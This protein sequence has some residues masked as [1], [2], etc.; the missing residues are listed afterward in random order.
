M[1]DFLYIMRTFL[2][3]RWPGNVRELRNGMEVAA[4]VVRCDTIGPD[5][6]S[7]EIL[8]GGIP[9]LAAGPIP[10]PAPRTLEEIERDAIRAALR[11]TGGNKTQAARVLGIG[12]R[13]LHRKVKDRTGR[14]ADRPTRVQHDP[15]RRPD[16][17]PCEHVRMERGGTP[18]GPLPPRSEGDRS[19]SLPC[20]SR[21][22]PGTCR[23]GMVGCGN[24]FSRQICPGNHGPRQALGRSCPCGAHLGTCRRGPEGLRKAA[25]WDSRPPARASSPPSDAVPYRGKPPVSRIS[26]TRKRNSFPVTPSTIRWSY[27]RHRYIIGRTTIASSPPASTTT[28]LLTT[29]PIRRIPT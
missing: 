25:R 20:Q 23:P 22:L 3:Y 8:G 18:P 27:P 1:R 17:P 9:P 13:T 2:A 24:S 21:R 29:C 5:D 11:E 6:L 15:P 19:P 7:P 4:L 14:A 28:A 10:L 16:S 12:L 26:R